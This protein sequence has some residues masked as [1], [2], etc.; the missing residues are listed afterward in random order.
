MKLFLSPHNDDA[1]LFGCF[2]L[3]REK[4]HV[5]I[6][7][8]CDYQADPAYGAPYEVRESET[9]AALAVLGVSWEQ[10]AISEANPDW[11]EMLRSLQELRRMGFDHV[12][13]PKPEPYGHPHHNKIGEL[14]LN[15]WPRVTQYCL[16]TLAGKSVGVEVPF[17]PRWVGLKLRALACHQ[18][19]AGGQNSHKYFIRDQRE[20]VAE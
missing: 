13:A 19:Q 16:Y 8:R 11:D 15:V 2:T 1:E 9:A 18:S 14:A 12:W 5:V 7:L 20:Y 10:W 17:H 6:C 4:P 3:L